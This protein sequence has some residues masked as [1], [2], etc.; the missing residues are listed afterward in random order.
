MRAWGEWF[1]PLL[2]VAAGRANEINS[3]EK[4]VQMMWILHCF[5]KSSKCHFAILQF[6]LLYNDA[7]VSEFFAGVFLLLP[8]AC[9]CF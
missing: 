3:V 1:V 4:D 5:F 2:C 9:C 6:L 7:N 8:Q